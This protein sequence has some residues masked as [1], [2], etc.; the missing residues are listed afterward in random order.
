MQAWPHMPHAYAISPSPSL[1]FTF[2]YFKFPPF[3]PLLF[4]PRRT[5][6]HVA[7]TR[8]PATATKIQKGRRY[9]IV[10]YLSQPGESNNRTRVETRP[11]E[12]K[13]RGQR[14]SLFSF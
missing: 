3:S 2:F 14:T 12:F 11:V 9:V 8:T 6:I 7:N 4:T 10:L 5:H 1:L 13:S